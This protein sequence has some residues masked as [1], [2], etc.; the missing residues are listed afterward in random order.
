M[1]TLAM[2]IKSFKIQGFWKMIKIS[3]CQY[4]K[5]RF[6]KCNLTPAKKTYLAT[7]SII[8]LGATIIMI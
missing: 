7:V 3:K 5:F 8:I 2:R 4:S 1:V 6:S